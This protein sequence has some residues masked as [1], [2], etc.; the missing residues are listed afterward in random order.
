[1]RPHTSIGNLR[2]CDFRIALAV[3]FDAEVTYTGLYGEA[4]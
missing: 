1:M 3:G 2:G 4:S